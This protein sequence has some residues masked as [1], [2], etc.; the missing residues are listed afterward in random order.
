MDEAEGRTAWVLIAADSYFFGPEGFVYYAIL[1]FQCQV[2]DRY[3]CYSSMALIPHSLRNLGT[4]Y[5]VNEERWEMKYHLS[6]KLQNGK[7][8]LRRFPDLYTHLMGIARSA[9]FIKST[10]TFPS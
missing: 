8:S 4:L 10:A 1:R 9:T 6:S 2:F 3:L 7:P 5:S